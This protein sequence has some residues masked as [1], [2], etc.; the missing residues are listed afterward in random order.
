MTAELA[1]HP[2]YPH[3]PRRSVCSGGDALRDGD[4][5]RVG[6]VGDFG[7]ALGSRIFSITKI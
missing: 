7:S 5:E 1:A 4:R 6:G 2:S 3:H